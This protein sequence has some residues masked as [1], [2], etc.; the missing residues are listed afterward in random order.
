MES[1]D[2]K[3]AGLKV[4][5]PRMKI[6][7]FLEASDVRHHSAESIYKTLLSDG[8]EIGL[9]TASSSTMDVPPQRRSHLAKLILPCRRPARKN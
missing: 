9:D 8:E 2:L 6:L 4:T 1:S 7:E 3:K 5:L